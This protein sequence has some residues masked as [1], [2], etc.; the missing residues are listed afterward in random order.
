MA[1]ATTTSITATTN[2]NLNRVLYGVTN[3]VAQ[4][5]GLDSK[6][7][8]QVTDFVAQ[9][10]NGEIKTVFP[11]VLPE[12]LEVFSISYEKKVILLGYEKG[13]L[14][15]C[16][17]EKPVEKVE[18]LEKETETSDSARGL[19]D[20]NRD[21]IITGTVRRVKSRLLESIGISIDMKAETQLFNFINQNEV[22]GR[23]GVLVT[24]NLPQDAGYATSEI[25]VQDYILTL[26]YGAN[27]VEN[28]YPYVI[29]VKAEKNQE[30]VRRE[31]MELKKKRLQSILPKELV[32]EVLRE[33]DLHYAVTITVY[34]SA[35]E[36]NKE[37]MRNKSDIQ[38]FIGQKPD[39]KTGSF[40]PNRP[41]GYVIGSSVVITAPGTSGK[42][43]YRI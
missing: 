20:L 19:S 37:R 16:I 24:R 10:I 32:N 18:I 26:V 11:K 39:P 41:I 12:G 15:A 34:G 1:N 28:A 40:V 3:Q 4:K 38:A 33:V 8:K 5:L 14:Y 6:A 7:K 43:I 36:W 30:A 9:R 27:P 23:I 31:A 13:I 17:Q 29:W 25:H 21:K 42:H 2:K 22:E 35:G